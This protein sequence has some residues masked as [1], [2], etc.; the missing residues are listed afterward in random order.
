M[1]SDPAQYMAI[2]LFVSFVLLIFTGYPVAWIMGGLAVLFTAISVFSDGYL[3][4]FFGV[5]WGYSSIVVAR[6]YAVMNNWVLVALPM[7]VFMGIMMDKSGIAED[8]MTDLARLFGRVRG[9]I[10]I[11]VVLIG[12]LLAASTGII[13][14]SVVLLAIL[15][16]PMMLK[17]N[18]DASLACGVVCATGTLG[19]LIPPSIMLVLMADQI[20]VS[21]GDL[22][23]GAMLPG[24]MLG[25]LYAAFILTYAWLR[26]SVAPAPED[27]QPV[28]F[29]LVLRV[30]KSTIPPATLIVAVLGS[31]FFGIATP[32]EASG[33]GALGA[34]LLALLRN[35]LSLTALREVLQ[36]TMKTTSY[37][38]ALFVGATAFSLVLRGFGGDA[39]IEDSLTALP[40]GPSGVVVVVLLITFLLGFVLD[41][42]E[43]TLIILPLLA[44]VLLGLGVDLVWFA[45]L[46]AVCLQTSFI[47]PP[48]GFALFYMK[49][50]A[51][52]GIDTMTIYKGIIPFMTIQLIGVALVF[53]FPKLATWLPTVAY[54]P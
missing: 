18:Y 48:V 34:T 19:I 6:I 28:S 25:G 17:H 3:D 16:V 39:L 2:A 4:T 37:I 20:R 15:G 29:G 44:P 53:S 33:V 26:P 50:V 52:K 30:L 24:L 42:I 11:T 36:G 54:G 12:V 10:A 32:T 9:G 47:T 21:V 46:F 27:A 31:I 38:F 5:D 43:I 1:I 41:W 8:L 22:F 49:G 7:F 35:R 45:V 40:F 51:P 14:A 13:G 23:M